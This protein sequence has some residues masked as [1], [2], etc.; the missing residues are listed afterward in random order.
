ME[1]QQSNPYLIT[2][3]HCG[4]TICGRCAKYDAD[5]E[6]LSDSMA[7]GVAAQIRGVNRRWEKHLSEYYHGGEYASPKEG[8]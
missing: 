5:I 1:Q 2:C 6:A 3:P 8:E 7:H 4:R